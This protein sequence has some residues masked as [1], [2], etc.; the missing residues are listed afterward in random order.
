M[1]TIRKVEITPVY[2][3]YM[4]PRE[5]MQPGALYISK[6][7]CIA[8]HLCLCGCGE[9]AVTPLTEIITETETF[10]SE[11]PGTDWFLTE[12]N[13]KVSMTP[14]IGNYSFPCKSHY[15]ITYNVANFV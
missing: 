9:L 7:G 13:G 5:E 11:M 6:Q 4:P 12:R 14:S 1:K 2:A 15:I 10:V 8:E 3:E